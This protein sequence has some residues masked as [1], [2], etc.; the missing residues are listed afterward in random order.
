MWLDR[1]RVAIYQGYGVHSHRASRP[2][3]QL[4]RSEKADN[5]ASMI[6]APAA[7][8]KGLSAVTLAFTRQETAA[9]LQRESGYHGKVRKF[10]WQAIMQ[11]L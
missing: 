8:F 9:A 3:C 11:G 4:E 5:T 6:C 7:V 2:R 1:I 10:S